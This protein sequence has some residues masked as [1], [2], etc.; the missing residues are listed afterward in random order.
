MAT[1]LICRRSNGPGSTDFCNVDSDLLLLQEGVGGTFMDQDTVQQRLTRSGKL[2]QTL[3]NGCIH[4]PLLSERSS[5]ILW[6]AREGRKERLLHSE[7]FLICLVMVNGFLYSQAVCRESQQN[8]LK[9][10]KMTSLKC[11]LPNLF[12]IHNIPLV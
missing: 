6:H 12:V 3:Q 11:H 10:V 2:L 8:A 1:K 4:R 7:K 5:T 9:S